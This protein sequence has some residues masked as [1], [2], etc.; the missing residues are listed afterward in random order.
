MQVD[1]LMYIP[2]ANTSVPITTPE[3]DQEF[4]AML[5]TLQKNHSFYF[6]YSLDLTKS[7]QNTLQELVASSGNDTNDLLR[8]FPNSIN[9]VHK[10]AFNHQLL[11]EFVDLQYA[12]FRVPCIYGFVS[13]QTID[14]STTFALISRKDSRRMGRRFVVRGLD[15]EGHA[16]NFVETEQIIVRK[17]P[18]GTCNIACHVQIRGSIPLLWKMKPNM[19]WA[20]PVTVTTNFD[21]S[22]QAAKN[23]FKETQAEYKK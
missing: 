1:K 16:A 5:E 18:T 13:I 6:S 7:V 23:H 22:L 21:E 19:Q 20:P 8:H 15:R 10:F 11:K 12:P 2:L 17:Q 14:A 9:Y 3:A 4:I